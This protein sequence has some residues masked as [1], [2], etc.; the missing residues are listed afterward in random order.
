MAELYD[1]ADE[2]EPEYGLLYPFTVCT[3]KG[4]PY[5]DQAFVA[6]VQFGRVAAAMER[7]E[8]L[9]G[10]VMVRSDLVPQIDLAAM[11]HGY[12]LSAEAW[13]EHPDEWSRATLTRGSGLG[14]APPSGGHTW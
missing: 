3:S 14:A 12:T 11:H 2:T 10:P 1:A 7:Q 9:I 13:D 5:E 8:P 4:G 6:G